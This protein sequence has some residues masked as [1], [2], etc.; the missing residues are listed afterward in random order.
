MDESDYMNEGQ[1]L[2]FQA[3]LAEMRTDILGR[4]AAVKEQLHEHQQFADPADR[5]TAEEEYALSL[6]LRERE[7]FLLKKIDEALGRIRR[8]EYGWCTATGEPIG[9]A[10]LIARPTASVCVHVKD[11]SERAE[12]HFRA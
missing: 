7:T 1:I 3:L 12:I 9:V 2:F 4:Q 8:H 6:R 5:A 10:R 11:Q